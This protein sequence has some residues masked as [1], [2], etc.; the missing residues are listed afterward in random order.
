MNRL[1]LI[2]I[3]LEIKSLSKLIEKATSDVD[4]AWVEEMR[5]EK[6]QLEMKLY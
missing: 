6:S 2:S 4:V 1:P 3:M 5:E